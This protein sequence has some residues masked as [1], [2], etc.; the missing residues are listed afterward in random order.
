MPLL[1]QIHV[2]VWHLQVSRTNN[3]YPDTSGYRTCSRDDILS[4][5]HVDGEKGYK[6]IQ[7]VSWLPATC[8]RCKCGNYCLYLVVIVA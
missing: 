3:L 7:L 4:L 1:H 6:W 8:I 5:I 2:A